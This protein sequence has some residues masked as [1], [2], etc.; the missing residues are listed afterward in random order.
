M[1]TVQHLR[2]ASHMLAIQA[3]MLINR[4]PGAL[5]NIMGADYAQLLRSIPGL[6]A[7]N[8]NN[9]GGNNNNGNQQQQQGRRPNMQPPQNPG[10]ASNPIEVV[11]PSQ[12]SN[13]TLPS[14]SNNP[15]IPTFAQQ[16]PQ[17]QRQTSSYGVSPTN[18]FITGQGQNA[19]NGNNTNNPGL[20]LGGLSSTPQSVTQLPNPSPAGSGI[21]S[22][23]ASV[24]AANLK[25]KPWA[26]MDFSKEPFAMEEPH[27]WNYLRSVTG[28][29]NLVPP[30]VQGKQVDLLALFNLVHRNGGSAKVSVGCS[31]ALLGAIFSLHPQHCIL[32]LSGSDRFLENSRGAK[33][34]RSL[35]Y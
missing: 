16:P 1:F 13:A 27:F 15:N 6:K 30:T 31:N 23:S 28:Q 21:G 4:F 8:G 32:I 9:G 10:S 20:G 24:S 18:P 2:Q 25:N 12:N 22:A 33:F 3:S 5:D 17:P 14:S 11:T 35:H 19:N 7:N 26:G 29:P 34:R